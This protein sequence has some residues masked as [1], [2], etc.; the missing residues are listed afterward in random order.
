MIKPYSIFGGEEEE[1]RTSCLG[2]LVG[3]I[4]AC[5]SSLVELGFSLFYLARV[6][7]S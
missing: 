6:L 3:V 5:W 1:K 7:E 2:G 4:L